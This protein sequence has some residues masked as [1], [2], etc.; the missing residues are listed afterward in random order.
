M[1]DVQR[2]TFAIFIES[3]IF[4]LSKSSGYLLFLHIRFLTRKLSEL[5]KFLEKVEIWNASVIGLPT[6]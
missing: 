5:K 1:F 2:W 3:S 4:G 6:H